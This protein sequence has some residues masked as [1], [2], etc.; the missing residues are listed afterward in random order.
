M[1]RVAAALGPSTA[2]AIA[3][4]SG[5]ANGL[6][7]VTASVSDGL[8]VVGDDLVVRFAHP[9]LASAVLAGMAPGER[10]SLHAALAGVV[11]DPDARA[12][13]L[14]LSCD[15][16][17]PDVAAEL[18]DAATRAARRG[19][20]ALAADFAGHSVRRHAAGRRRGPGPPG[21]R[22]RVASRRVR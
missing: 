15:D 2:Q 13:H 22:R 8:L 10:Q 5:L 18:H 4:A 3:R 14:A 11:D 12:R 20:L 19:A 17:D 6:D 16:P 1:L 7:S 21:V 9:L